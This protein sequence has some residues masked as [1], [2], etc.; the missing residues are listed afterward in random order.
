MAVSVPGGDL[1]SGTCD[2]CDDG[3]PTEDLISYGGATV[4]QTCAEEMEDG[5]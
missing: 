4:C 2:R 3:M 1:A 5:R